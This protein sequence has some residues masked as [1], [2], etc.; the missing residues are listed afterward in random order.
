MPDSSSY[1]PV[2][3]GVAV[4]FFAGLTRKRQRKLIGLLLQLAEEPYQLGDFESSDATGRRLEN[5]ILDD[6]RVTYW[7]DHAARELRIMDVAE[8]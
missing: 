1:D 4:Q 8:L 6:W 7:A 5:I 2:L 3:S